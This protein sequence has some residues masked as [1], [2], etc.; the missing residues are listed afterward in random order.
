MYLRGGWL[1]LKHGPA[2]ETRNKTK[3]MSDKRLLR[4]R[5]LL[6]KRLAHLGNK[7]NSRLR[8]CRK[9]LRQCPS[10]CSQAFVVGGRSTP[11]DGG[12]RRRNKG[13]F[14]SF[15]FRSIEQPHDYYGNVFTFQST[16][17]NYFLSVLFVY[18][19]R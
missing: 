16:R 15:L 10:R 6:F 12:R 4:W 8:E 9:L 18:L 11:I 17:T 19:L 5:L 3:T 1:N 13:I 7:S 14:R 2:I